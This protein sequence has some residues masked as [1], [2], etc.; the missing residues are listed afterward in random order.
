MTGHRAAPPGHA[1]LAENTD[2]QA[3]ALAEVLGSDAERLLIGASVYREPAD[4]DALLFQ[5]GQ[6]DLAAA[7]AP[8]RPSPAPPYRE[9]A[10]LDWMIA[11]CQSAGLLIP[12]F[13]SA[14]T[15]FV[16]RWTAGE[17]N[18]VLDSANRG[19]DLV[20]AHQ[21]AAEYWRWRAE[22]RPQEHGDDLHDLIEA[23]FH[24]LEAGEAAQAS[25]LTKMA[26][27]GLHA[28]GDFGQEAALISDTLLR[29]PE[30]SAERADWIFGLGKIAQVRTDYAAAERCFKQAMDAFASA[31]DR[32]GVSRCH[33]SL[34]VLAQ[35]RGEYAD[36]ELCYQRS[37]DEVSNRATQ[38][39]TPAPQTAA[40]ATPAVTPATPAAAQAPQT[41]TPATQAVTPAPSPTDAQERRAAWRRLTGHAAPWRAPGLAGLALGLLALSV[42]E[43]FTTLGSA[44]AAS[45]TPPPA[46]ASAPSTA[47]SAPST[48]T[49][50]PSTATSGPSAAAGQEA[51]AWVAGQ[52]SRSAVVSCDP[53]MCSELETRG[54]PAGDLLMLGPGGP[55]GAGGPGGPAG[56][57]S[58]GPLGSDVVVATRT[59]RS[60]FGSRLADVYAPVVLAAFGSGGERVEIRA[61]APGGAAAYRDAL[62][63]DLAARRQAGA[64]LLRNPDIS[65]SAA[66]RGPLADGS[67]DS[68]LLVTFA[69]L[70]GLRLVHQIRIISFGEPDPGAG[71]GVPVRSAEI[72]GPSSQAILA[73]LRA[74]QAPYL[75]AVIRAIQL[76]GGQAAVSL[77][78]ASPSPLGL[79]ATANP[80]MQAA[81]PA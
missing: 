49:S 55:G 41:A 3:A 54:V 70:A 26:C 37:A 74:Q 65:A 1:G 71:A 47:T 2:A 69:V 10:N 4:R 42:T 57:E 25:R 66:A 58:A 31:G 63:T 81:P 50:G 72:A 79:L 33:Y 7:W 43:I 51:A 46:A 60:E 13:P 62:A 18:R 78:F 39:A 20:A 30:H 64:Q 22:A 28:R 73:F 21:R 59:V 8:G 67:V 32:A 56:P 29:L 24:L 17:L 68:R 61:I 80:T 34:G 11:E 53:A 27:S 52:I 44:G 35:A 38:A 19:P 9:P 14:G 76:P 16:D 45:R 23:R 77:G 6:P 36:A 5:V 40:P 12:G 15:I 48:A 75:A